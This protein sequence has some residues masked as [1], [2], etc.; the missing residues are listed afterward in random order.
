[1]RSLT[2]NKNTQSTFFSDKQFQGGKIK[3]RGHTSMTIKN[4][5]LPSCMTPTKRKLMEQNNTYTLV[6]LFSTLP[7]S[8][9]GG[10]DESESP[11]KRIK[12]RKSAKEGPNILRSQD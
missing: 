8:D 7:K 9:Q 3:T 2:K 6:K 11:A 12:L 5:S 1:M 4:T 10:G